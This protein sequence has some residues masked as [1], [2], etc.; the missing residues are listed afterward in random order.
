[1]NLE[2][3]QALARRYRVPLAALAILLAALLYASGV[4]N[5]PPGFHVDES[6]VSYNAY[7]IAQSGRDEDGQAW[8]LFFRAFGEYKNPT[9]IYLLAAL[10]KLTGPSILAGRALSA[11]AGL[12]AA[13]L[14]GLLAVKI[15]G[16]RAVGICCGLSALV[17]PW[18]FE[19][20]RVVMEVALYPLV[21]VL[22]LLCLQRV[23][24]RQRWSH[25]DV[26]L[27]ALTLALLTYTYSIGRLLAPLLALGLVLF[28]TRERWPSVLRAWGAYLLTLTPL[29][30]FNGRHPGAMTGRLMYM[31]YVTPQSSYGELAAEF[32]RHYAGN[33]NPWRLLVS[34]DPN[35]YQV[36]H[37]FGTPH[38]L[39]GTAAF[40][41]VG[42]CLALRRHWR[43]PWWRFI[44]YGLLVS[45]V[46]ASL[47]TDYVHMLR[48][49][50][51]PIF[52][53]VLSVPAFAWFAET[54]HRQRYRRLLFALLLTLTVLQGAVFQWQFRQYANAPWRL[55]LFDAEYPQNI[56]ARALNNPSRPVYLADAPAVPGYIQAYWYATL[57]GVDLKQFLRLSGEK[58]APQGALT[59]TTEEN[60]LRCQIIAVNEPY[61]LYLASAPPRSLAPLEPAALR[62][63]IYPLDLPARLRAGEKYFARVRVRNVSASPW[64]ARERALEPYQV[65]LGNHWLNA[66]G[67][68]LVNDDGRRPLLKD[69]GPGDEAEL[70][71]SINAPGRAGEYL[72]ELDMLQEG[73]SWFGLGGSPTLRVRVTVE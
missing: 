38:L 26:A 11:A 14:L 30:V 59:I 39:A 18:L 72:L 40:A 49:I 42:I 32:I 4:P 6:S 1:M 67:E 68:T 13:L 58:P 16:R 55:H 3:G 52:L 41:V 62:A 15:S 51:F 35:P 8:P 7:T 27:L 45:V 25:P 56:L 29:F 31:T 69:I 71:L 47:T 17:T 73:V 57:Q 44:I 60:C 36:A 21:L 37:V 28:V 33:L 24:A 66:N 64:L 48:L 53:L 9:Y 22:F 12:M 2:T 50:A 23:S 34:G 63:E 43:E 46:P 61:T 54:D 70:T 10:F 19:T 65:S 5:N 20:S